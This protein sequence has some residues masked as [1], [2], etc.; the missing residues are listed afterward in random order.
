MPSEERMS[1]EALGS[2]LEFGGLCFDLNRKL[3]FS[4][5]VEGVGG[6]RGNYLRGAIRRYGG[7]KCEGEGDRERVLIPQSYVRTNRAS[8]VQ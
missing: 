5:R 3:I 2:A 4:S 6:L 7:A 1:R 8:E